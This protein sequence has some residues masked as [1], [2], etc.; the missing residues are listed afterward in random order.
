[1]RYRTSEEAS[2][3]ERGRATIT[4][5]GKPVTVESANVRELL[6]RLGY[7]A[8]RRGMAVALNGR[9]LPRGGWDE[10]RVCDGDELE[11]VGA[12]QGG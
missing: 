11:I 12:V 3:V 1:M 6:E 10:R 4:L 2:M 5:N 8:E 7:D 9:V